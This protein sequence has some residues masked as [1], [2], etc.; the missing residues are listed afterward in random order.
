MYRQGFLCVAYAQCSKGVIVD[1]GSS[2]LN[3]R[4]ALP[5]IATDSDSTAPFCPNDTETCCQLRKF[6]NVAEQTVETATSPAPSVESA[7]PTTTPSASPN[8]FGNLG[9]DDCSHYAEQVW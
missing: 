4:T 3:V 7:A 6:A 5:D 1:D 8:P 9:P 2:L